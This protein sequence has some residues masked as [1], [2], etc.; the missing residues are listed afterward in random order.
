MKIVSDL[1]IESSEKG[2]FTA[3]INPAEWAQHGHF[4]VARVFVNYVLQGVQPSSIGSLNG[5]PCNGLFAEVANEFSDDFNAPLVHQVVISNT[6][7]IER[8]YSF[9]LDCLAVLQ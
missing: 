4:V 6:K 3:L 8:I 2:L 5:I 7:S 9:K 1:W